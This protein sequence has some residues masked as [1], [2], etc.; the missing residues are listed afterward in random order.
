MAL[1][2]SLADTRALMNAV[3]TADDNDVLRALRAASRRVDLEMG[4]RRPY[5]EPYIETRTVRVRGTSLSNGGRTL[6]LPSPLLSLTSAAVSGSQAPTVQTAISDAALSPYGV[7]PSSELTI[8]GCCQTWL[9]CGDCGGG[10]SALVTG[11]WG[12]HGDYAQAWVALDAL[13][14]AIISATATTLTVAD[15]DGVDEYEIAPRFSPGQ[16]LRIDSEFLEVTGV[17]TTT[18][19]LTVRR[20]AN[21]ST[22]DTHLIAAAVEVWRPE[23]VIRRAVARQAGLMYAR[24]GAYTTVSVEATGTEIRYPVDLLVELRGALQEFAYGI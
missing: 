22:A 11:I 8:S 23:D 18:N 21:G 7:T 19:V 24:Q 5:F 13:A 14:A 2:A 20:G 17:N 6:H 3:G 1:Y 16:L 9:A 15:A 12:Y 10:L 4:A